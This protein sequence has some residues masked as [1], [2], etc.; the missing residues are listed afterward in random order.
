ME[1]MTDQ[2]L[3]DL[4]FAPATALPVLAFCEGRISRC[5]QAACDLV[6]A[7]PNQPLDTLFDE[8][9]RVKLVAALGAAPSSCELQAYAS[10]G[11]L[12]A[13][14][15]SIVPWANDEYIAFV[16]HVGIGY[17]ERLSRQLLAAN[18]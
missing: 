14:R 2:A 17:G 7:E 8:R 1:A 16:T 9:S 15:I 5:S 10:D 13:V 3:V 6:H 12:V 11:E 4:L 18:D